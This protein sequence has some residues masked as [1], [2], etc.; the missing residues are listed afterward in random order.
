MNAVPDVGM[1]AAADAEPAEACRR[2]HRSSSGRWLLLIAALQAALALRP[3]LNRN[4]FQ[5]E[6][7]YLY[8]GHRMIDHILHG[9]FLAEHP[10]GY[11]SG[12][13][14]LYPVLAALADAT[15][16][17]AAARALSLVFAILAMLATY[18]LGRQLFGALAGLFAAAAFALCG[19]V[20]FQSHLATYDAMAM[21]LFAAGAWLAVTSAR[22]DALLWAPVVAALLTAA[23]LVKYATAVYIPGIAVL[24]AVVGWPRYRWVVVRRAGFMIAA[25][26]AMTY[27]CL[28]LWGGDLVPGII[29]TTA[30]RSVLSP[31]GHAELARMVLIWIGPWLAL[32]TTAALLRPGRWP[33]SAA[34]LMLSVIAPLEQIRIGES[35]SLA[36]HV[37]FGMVFACPLIG[38]LLARVIN[39]NLWTGASAAALTLSVLLGCGL[40]FSGQFLSS[41]AD[42]RALL[43]ALRHNLAIAHGKALLGEE[44]SAQRYELRTSTAPL[45]WTDTFSFRYDGKTGQPAYV[46]AIQQSHFGTIYLT[47]NTPNGRF[48][49]RYLTTTN[50]PYRLAAKIPSYRHGK[51]AG[52]WLLW[53]PKVDRQ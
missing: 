27:F 3:G 22:R 5:D 47:L 15:G 44:P 51:R 21:C 49:N 29:S 6:G 43:P 28:E 50:T 8:M 14:G 1:P 38:D 7:L 4:A 10:G 11:F 42:D 17:L 39:R 13:P 45:Q 23:F 19:S 9:A 16:G 48:I 46:Q 53:T 24:A 32:A 25:A 12:A 37:A 20:I 30:D 41:W 36:K 35:T 52:L 33:T 40:H 31:A 34:L 2:W 26:A 18:L